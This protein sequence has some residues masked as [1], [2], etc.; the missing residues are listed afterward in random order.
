MDF[1]SWCA[2]LGGISGMAR[3]SGPVV[4]SSSGTGTKWPTSSGPMPNK[5]LTQQ[6]QR[7]APH[8]AL[9]CPSWWRRADKTREPNPNWTGCLDKPAGDR[10]RDAFQA[11]SYLSWVLKEEVREKLS[12]RGDWRVPRTKSSTKHLKG[13]GGRTR[14]AARAQWHQAKDR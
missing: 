14:G 1:A 11:R 2:W 9:W 12:S 8:S 10:I 6:M 5:L 13:G 4:K 3:S 7:H